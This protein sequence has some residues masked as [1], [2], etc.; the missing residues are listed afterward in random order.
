MKPLF[1]MHSLFCPNECDLIAK[2]ERALWEDFG[3]H[4]GLI[5][6]LLPP[7]Q[8]YPAECD[9]LYLLGRDGNAARDAVKEIKESMYSYSSHSVTSDER[10]W[11]NDPTQYQNKEWALVIKRK[12]SV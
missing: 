7:G 3:N 4:E 11:R 12:D 9:R 10:R 5:C 8:P 2:R 1:Y 6:R